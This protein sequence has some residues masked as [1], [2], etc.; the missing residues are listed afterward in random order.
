[1][2]DEL[3]SD[4]ILNKAFAFASESK[5][6]AIRGYDTDSVI[7]GSS[8]E[9]DNINNDELVHILTTYKTGECSRSFS[10]TLPSTTKQVSLCI[11]RVNNSYY[12]QPFLEFLVTMRRSE[13]KRTFGFPHVSR[14]VLDTDSKVDDMIYELSISLKADVMTRGFFM[15][16]NITYMLCQITGFDDSVR[17]YK[18][19]NERSQWITSGELVLGKALSNIMVSPLI[20]LLV[21]EELSLFTLYKM[22]HMVRSPDIYYVGGDKEYVNF[23]SSMIRTPINGTT[24][25]FDK[26]VLMDCSTAYRLTN[27]KVPKQFG[28]GCFHLLGNNPQPNSHILKIAV[29]HDVIDAD[30]TIGY[31]DTL[32]HGE[33]LCFWYGFK[34]SSC[35]IVAVYDVV[36]AK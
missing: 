2:V 1:M 7:S 36:V 29:F 13:D 15:V 4:K 5:D 31:C 9:N 33:R 28:K 10:I 14:D 35:H 30:R 3:E 24:A 27:Y 20:E 19:V 26:L 17:T 21:K 25:H 18:S 12:Q 6:T 22:K 8:D 16:K 32:L 23:I 11:Y 34:P